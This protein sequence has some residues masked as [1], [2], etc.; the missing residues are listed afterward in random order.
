[1]RSYIC[2]DKKIRNKVKKAL[3]SI[4]GV[5][6]GIANVVTPEIAVATGGYS[7][8]DYLASSVPIL[9]AASPIVVAGVVV[10]LYTLGLDAFCRWSDALRTDEH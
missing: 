7:L 6:M 4:P 9:G 10:I 1:L 5:R 3:K 2:S 8:G